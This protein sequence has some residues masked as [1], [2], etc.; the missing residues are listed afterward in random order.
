MYYCENCHLLS[1]EPICDYCGSSD[2]RQPQADDFCYL[3]TRTTP[4]YEILLDVLYD[5]GIPWVVKPLRPS[6]VTIYL[7]TSSELNEIFVP[8]E[9][10][11]R[12]KELEKSIFSEEAMVEDI[13]TDCTELP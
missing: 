10:L 7:G 8:Y 12:A 5:N 3:T 9:K 13:I 2:L 11:E 4:W 6:A 1:E